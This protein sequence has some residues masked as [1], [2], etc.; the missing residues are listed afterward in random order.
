MEHILIQ[1]H[2][3]E[4]RVLHDTL[5]VARSV[6][7][8]NGNDDV[9]DEL[10]SVL[11]QLPRTSTVDRVNFTPREWLLVLDALSERPV[12]THEETRALRVEHLRKKLARRLG[13][14]VRE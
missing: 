14:E 5:Q 9:V 4:R 7:E 10:E 6:Y 8:D 2:H 13:D 11:E 12:V 3:Y 1:L